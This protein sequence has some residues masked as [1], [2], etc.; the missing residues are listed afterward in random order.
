VDDFLIQSWGRNSADE[1]FAYTP[2]TPELGLFTVSSMQDFDN[3]L[4]NW[5]G[6]WIRAPRVATAGT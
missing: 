3:D 2:A 4:V 5:N 6:S 1:G